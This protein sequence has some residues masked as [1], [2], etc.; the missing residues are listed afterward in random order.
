MQEERQAAIDRQN[1]VILT[2]LMKIKQ[3]P[4]RVDY[5]NKDWK[6]TYVK[7]NKRVTAWSEQ[8]G[9]NCSYSGYRQDFIYTWHP[10][11][12]LLMRADI[13]TFADKIKRE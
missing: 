5:W 8:K 10:C 4:A 6:P 11:S 12:V 1:Q 9:C 7:V 13:Q 3:S 2:Q